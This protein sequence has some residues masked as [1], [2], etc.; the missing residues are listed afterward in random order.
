MT[1]GHLSNFNAYFENPN[2]ETFD[3]RSPS[4]RGVHADF[5]PANSP[6]PGLQNG[7]T[8][9]SEIRRVFEIFAIF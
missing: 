3:G 1:R 9:A 6:R 4:I 2:F 7:L 5:L 8:P